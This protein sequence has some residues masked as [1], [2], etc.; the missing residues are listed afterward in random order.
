MD[1]KPVFNKTCP[2]C[3]NAFTSTA[4][5]TKYC[6]E[7]CAKKGSVQVRKTSK[8]RKKRRK[9]IESSDM[10]K[11]I[12]QATN[13]AYSLAQLIGDMF[14]PFECGCKEEGHVCEGPLHL[15]HKDRNPFNNS[16][17]NLVFLCEKAHDAEHAG[18][19]TNA[20]SESLRISY[21]NK[22]RQQGSNTVYEFEHLPKE[23]T[24]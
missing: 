14:I 10:N 5:N 23:C 16:L 18:N 2:I 22:K 8:A 7:E 24:D 9:K 21:K 13:R 3:H 20:F 4:R 12:Q 6:C 15:H 11:L 17:D 19:K 1:G